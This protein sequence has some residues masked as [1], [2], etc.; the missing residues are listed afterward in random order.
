[1]CLCNCLSYPACKSHFFA[2]YYI[3]ICGLFGCAI[4]SILSHKGHNFPQNKCTE[5]EMWVLNLSTIFVWNIS[6]SQTNPRDIIIN[7]HRC[8]CKVHVALV[9][10]Q[11]KLNFLDRF[12]KNPRIPNLI[13]IYPVGA[14]LLRVRTDGWTHRHDEANSRFSQFFKRA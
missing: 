12:Y 8:L 9:K 7:V 13:K 2:L 1:V 3:V 6:Q 14:E 10:F 4:F 5:Y 11:W